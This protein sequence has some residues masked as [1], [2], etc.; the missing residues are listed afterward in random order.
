MTTKR[1]RKTPVTAATTGTALSTV[2]QAQVLASAAA[3]VDAVV[4]TTAAVVDAA[5]NA[6]E[7]VVKKGRAV[8]PDSKVQRANAIFAE[9]YA[10]EKVPQRKDILAKVQTEIGLTVHGSATYLHNYRA[11]NG[12]VTKKG[13]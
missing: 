10:M 11:K 12:M 6:V 1:A 3:V 8:N 7:A 2:V 13:E 9:C 5:V 4:D